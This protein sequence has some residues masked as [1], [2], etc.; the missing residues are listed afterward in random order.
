MLIKS[1]GYSEQ[2]RDLQTFAVNNY[3]EWHYHTEGLKLLEENEDFIRAE[4]IY[5][6]FLREDPNSFI[7]HQ[8]KAR[9]QIE[10]GRYDSALIHLDI[11]DALNPYNTGNYYYMGLVYDKKNEIQKAK[12]C[13][14]KS[15]HHYNMNPMP[16]IAMAELL[17]KQNDLDSA[18]YYLTSVSDT[19]NLIPTKLYYT[20]GILSLNLSD[21]VRAQ[22][23]FNKYFELGKD[24]VVIEEI[25]KIKNT[26]P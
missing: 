3:P 15:I 2:A 20:A 10:T 11:A 12:E 16:Y 8:T 25:N 26:L 4:Y 13:F 24:S 17:Y 1:W 23:Y 21:T 22:T 5:D 18:R 9:I 19:L 6:E 14:A 7:A